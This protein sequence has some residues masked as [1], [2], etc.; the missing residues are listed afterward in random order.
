MPNNGSIDCIIH[1]DMIR[2]RQTTAGVLSELDQVNIS[3]T[4]ILQ[5]TENPPITSPENDE[6]LCPSPLKC[7]SYPLLES[8]LL[9]EGPPPVEPE[10]SSGRM[11]VLISIAIKLT[12][13]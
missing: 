3:D 10:P 4:G 2:A 7:K 12:R 6:G 9:A 5:I 13:I 1:S 11:P 8:A